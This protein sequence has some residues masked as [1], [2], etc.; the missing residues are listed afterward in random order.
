MGCF[1]ISLHVSLIL[2][3]AVMEI[4]HAIE[5]APFKVEEYMDE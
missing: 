5:I 2:E 4:I 3:A 1:S